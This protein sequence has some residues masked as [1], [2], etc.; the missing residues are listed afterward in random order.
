MNPERYQKVG[1]LFYAALELP[2][3]SRAAFLDVACGGDDDLRQEVES[4]L[5]PTTRP[6]TSWPVRPRTWPR[7]VAPQ[8]D[9]ETGAQRKHRRLRGALA[10]RPRRHGRSL[11]GA[12]HPAGPQG[13]GQSAPPALTSN[14]DAVRRF[15]QEARAASSLNHPNIVTIYEIGDLL[16]AASSPWSSSKDGRWPRW[17]AARPRRRA[18]APGRAAGA[19]PLGGACR[20]DRAPRHQAGERHRPRGRL[21]EGARLRAGAPAAG[22][23]PTVGRRTTGHGPGSSSARRAT[24]R[25]S[26]RGARR[27]APATCS[28]SAWSSTSSRRA[29]T[30]ST[31]RRCSA[32]FTPSS[33][34]TPS[35]AAGCACMPEARAPAP[36]HAREGRRGRPTAAEVE[37]ELAKLAAALLERAR[38][39]PGPAVE[40]SAATQPAVPTHGARRTHAELTASRTCCSIPRPAADAD[41][42][43][44]DGKDAPGHPGRRGSRRPLR[45]RG[46]V[47]QPRPDCRPEP[48]GIRR[49]PGP[50]R[51]GDRRSSAGARRSPSTFA[52]SARRSWSWTTSS[53]SP[54]P[55]PS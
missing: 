43:W 36:S 28:R 4:L 48:G 22:P 12:R 15:E 32:R 17:S 6:A 30:R 19:G 11:P 14:P 51:S 34:H 26:R 16:T 29:F 38:Q 54:M 44:R 49:G 45:R 5:R 10:R 47:R 1:Q 2:P 40:T 20:G 46:L 33:S 42:A 39:D 21:R 53:R 27:R 13:G 41:R 9:A 35:P 37:A 8:E 55:P 52:A 31:P 23:G 25:R 7:L 24:C 3:E 18:G 50:R